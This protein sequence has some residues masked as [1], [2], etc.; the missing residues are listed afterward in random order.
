MTDE[1]SGLC[2]WMWL[3]V[4][5]KPTR[6]FNHYLWYVAGRIRLICHRLVDDHK[7]ELCTLQARRQCYHQPPLDGTL[8]SASLRCRPQKKCRHIRLNYRT[9]KELFMQIRLITCGGLIIC[10]LRRLPWTPPF[11]LL[12]LSIVCLPCEVIDLI[13]YFCKI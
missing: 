8:W 13:F 10:V 2:I 7:S 5:K 11:H 4:E 3:Q 12:I 6:I 1:W 9:H